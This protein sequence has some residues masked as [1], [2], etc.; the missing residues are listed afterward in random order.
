MSESERGQ[1]NSSREIY[2]FSTLLVETDD[3]SEAITQ[4]CEKTFEGERFEKGDPER[5][6]L[7]IRMREV[8]GEYLAQNSEIKLPEKKPV[9]REDR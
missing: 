5:D 8:Y 7:L 4:M 3:F 6:R 1:C 9:G 2:G